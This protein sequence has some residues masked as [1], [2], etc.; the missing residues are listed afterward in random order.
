MTI[1]KQR[2]RQWAGLI[3]LAVL[4]GPPWTAAEDLQKTQK[5]E[6]ESAAKALI[7]EAKSLEGS[8]KLVEARLK[9]AESLGYIELNDA[10]QAVDRLNKELLN[11]A[12]SAIQTAKKHLRRRKVS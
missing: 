1:G 5:K 7:G 8:G 11:Q 2:V 12:K 4:A 3:L 9:Y 10:T 6:L